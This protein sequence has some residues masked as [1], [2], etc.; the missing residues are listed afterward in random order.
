MQPT[1]FLARVAA[2]V[3]PPRHPLIRF[4]G[5]FAPHS[6]WRKKIVPVPTAPPSN[7]P[8][9]TAG[10]PNKDAIERSRS[11]TKRG[12]RTTSTAAQ[13]PSAMVSPSHAANAGMPAGERFPFARIDWG[14][15]P[16]THPR[17]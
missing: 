6:A 14:R 3:P 13:S 4:H 2:L 15:A 9:S 8:V 16:Q 10:D 12:D 7:C 1:A 17:R 11:E 5:V